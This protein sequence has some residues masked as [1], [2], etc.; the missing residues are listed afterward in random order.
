MMCDVLISVIIPVYNA[1]K[2]LTECIESV[3]NQK[4]SSWQMILV[5][6]GSK[7]SSPD[8]CKEFAEKD[9]RILY[10]RQ[11][12]AGVSA[13]RNAGI[14]Q[15]KGKWITFLDADDALSA[16]AFSLLSKQD[17][18]AQMILAGYSN[19]AKTFIFDEKQKQMS[20]GDMQLCI[21]DIVT[22]KA[23]HKDTPMIGH[24]NHWSV[25]GR[26]FKADIIQNNGILFSE[27]IRL[28]EDLLFCM[29]YYNFIEEVTLN[30]STIYFYRPNES[31]VSSTFQN[32]R[33][34]NTILLV[35]SVKEEIQTEKL[36]NSYYR[37]VVNRLVKCC[38]GYYSNPKCELTVAGKIESLKNLCERNVIACAISKAPYN[39]LA[40]GKKSM[41]MS[42][43][44]LFFL[45]NRRY[46]MALKFSALVANKL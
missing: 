9:E 31:S 8:I 43:V 21:L 20:S 46:G 40:P 39:K 23:K 33:I 41:L 38:V 32:N 36:M 13:A 29:Q 24:Y 15:A 27:D 11:E 17:D 18:N 16:D 42:A 6:D 25:W 44:I 1:E 4:E 7:D 26:F 5:D 37:F 35:K 19:T 30:N 14:K 28:G 45:K 2:Y 3:L 10:I 12:N 34:N 22:F